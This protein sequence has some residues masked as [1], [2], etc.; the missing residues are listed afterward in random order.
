MRPWRR[1]SPD[2]RQNTRTVLMN[3]LSRL[4]VWNMG[5]HVEQHMN[6]T[7]PFHSLPRLHEAMSRDCPAPYPSTWAAWREMVPGSWRQR[8]EPTFFVR[9]PYPAPRTSPRPAPQRS[10]RPGPWPRPCH[11]HHAALDPCGRHCRPSRGRRH[12]GRGRR[13]L[14]GRVPERRRVLRQRRASAPMNMPVFATASSSTIWLNALSTRAA[15]TFGAGRRRVPPLTSRCAPTRCVSR[16][17]TL[18]S[19]SEAT[20]QYPAYEPAAGVRS[21]RTGD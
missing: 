2:W 1:E 14:F 10:P 17:L 19:A 7:V 20:F 21:T 8:H 3:P 6:P 18:R 15:P 13:S 4:L 11:E 5:F 16:A 12:R 9:R